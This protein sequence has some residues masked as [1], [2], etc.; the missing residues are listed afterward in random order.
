MSLWKDAKSP[1]LKT[2]EA[3]L[4]TAL[5]RHKAGGAALKTVWQAGQRIGEMRLSAPRIAGSAAR[6]PAQRGGTGPAAR[7]EQSRAALHQVWRR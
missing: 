6:P 1:A 3:A 4:L 2:E 7:T 5:P